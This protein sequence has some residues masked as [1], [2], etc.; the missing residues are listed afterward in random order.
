MASYRESQ[1]AVNAF[2]AVS[3]EPSCH[4][5]PC[6]TSRPAESPSQQEGPHQMWLP[7]PRLPRLQ[8]CIKYIFKN[9]LPSLLYS[10]IA[11][12]NRL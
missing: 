10:V 7:D 11:M 5:M 6:P 9:K 8:R 12:Q 4:V 2:L 3:H 1:F